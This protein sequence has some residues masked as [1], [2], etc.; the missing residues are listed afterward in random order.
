MNYSDKNMPIELYKNHFLWQDQIMQNNSIVCIFSHRIIVIDPSFNFKNIL[1]FLE[2]KKL[3]IEVVLTHSHYDHVG[4][5]FDYQD[6]ISKLYVSKHLQPLI[7]ENIHNE[8]FFG[9]KVNLDNFDKT[10]IIYIDRS[11]ILEGLKFVLTPGHSTDSLCMYSE[12]LIIT[13]DLLFTNGIGRTDLPFSNGHDMIA[14]LK[15]IKQILQDNPKAILIPGHGRWE[16]AGH[17]LKN[18]QYLINL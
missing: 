2:D 14:S 4:D 15:K 17:V 10:K 5:L 6:Q 16:T 8:L 7:K 11:F 3:P 13:G 12:E 1:K 18:N 9:T